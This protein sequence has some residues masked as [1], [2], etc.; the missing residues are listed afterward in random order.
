M[1]KEK[2]EEMVRS[3]KSRGY[4]ESQDI[5]KAFL[6][7]PREKFV[8]STLESS[9]YDDHPLSI[10]QGQTISAPS[11]VAIML[12]ALDL[13]EGQKILEIGTGS[14]YNAALLSEVA[15]EDGEIYTIERLEAIA[16]TGRKNLEKVGYD[17]IKVA[18]GDGTKGY[19]P[20]SPWDRIL[21]TAC[22]PEIPEPLVDQLKIGGKLATPVGKHYMSQNLLVVEK[23][24]EDETEIQNHGGCAFVPLVGEYGWGEQKF[25]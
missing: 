14:G 24:G 11:M 23:T 6:N 22:A 16:E 19:Q 18:V 12:E 1:Y 13:S 10:G 20:E 7:V 3:L 5:E 8:P 15:G 9:A 25:R 2:R 21:V 17:Q 4:I